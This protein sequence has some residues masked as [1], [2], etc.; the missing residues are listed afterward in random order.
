MTVCTMSAA[1]TK[2]GGGGAF[3]SIG[4]DHH[5]ESEGWDVAAAAP[6]PTHEKR[7]AQVRSR[8][9]VMAMTAIVQHPR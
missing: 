7:A 3:S 1:L 9:R 4:R 6:M 8:A 2:L 5:R